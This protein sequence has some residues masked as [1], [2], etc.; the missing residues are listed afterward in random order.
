MERSSCQVQQGQGWSS[1]RQG[2]VGWTGDCRVDRGL[3][4]GQGMWGGQGTIG[5]TGTVGWTEDCRVDREC[6][7]DRGL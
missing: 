7:V 4:G 3:L 1:P 2:T 6:G 5:W